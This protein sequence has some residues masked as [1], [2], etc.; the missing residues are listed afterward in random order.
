MKQLS[1]WT[2]A[3]EDDWEN[4]Y[5]RE[6]HRSERTKELRK[7]QDRIAMRSSVN[8]REWIRGWVKSVK[9]YGIFVRIS[10]DQD[11]FVPTSSM[12]EDATVPDALTKGRV[13]NFKVGAEASVRVNSYQGVDT[14]GRDKYCCSMLP[15]SED[16]E[17][18]GSRNEG[19]SFGGKASGKGVPGGRHL[20]NASTMV[21]D[22]GS[23]VQTLDAENLARDLGKTNRKAYLA[24]KGFAVVDDATSMELNEVCKVT[25]SCKKVKVESKPTSVSKLLAVW[26]NFGQTGRP[27][28]HINIQGG[29]SDQEKEKRAI[30]LCIEEA[31]DQVQDGANVDRIDVG[32]KVIQV[33]LKTS[34]GLK[35][36]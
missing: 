19:G 31:N 23:E 14:K 36:K 16:K 30:D 7:Q 9:T 5:Q 27:V 10:E 18:G 32:Q 4:S 20:E 8:P 35:V 24:A 1:M 11:L 29:L 15:I 34:S 17:F 33:R 25:D 21:L 22:E 12:P 3:E 26:L 2:S 13:P 6:K 28:G